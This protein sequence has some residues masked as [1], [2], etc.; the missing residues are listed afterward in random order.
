MMTHWTSPIIDDNSTADIEREFLVDLRE[1]RVLLD[2]EREHKRY[3]DYNTCDCIE[4]ERKI[5]I[6]L[7]C[8]LSEVKGTCKR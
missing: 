3:Y 8:C 4:M 7:Q 6:S 2:K 1:L 5:S